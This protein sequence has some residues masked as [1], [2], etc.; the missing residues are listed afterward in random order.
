MESLRAKSASSSSDR[1]RKQV[2]LWLADTGT[3]TNAPSESSSSSSSEITPRHSKTRALAR[4]S[5]QT[6]QETPES[7]VAAPGAPHSPTSVMSTSTTHRVATLRSK[8]SRYSNKMDYCDDS[9]DEWLPPQA[10][11]SAQSRKRPQS[12][13]EKKEPITMHHDVLLHIMSYLSPKPLQA[14]ANS[15]RALQASITTDMVVKSAM[16]QGGQGQKL[17]DAIRRL[18]TKQSIHPPSPKRLLKLVNCATAGRCEECGH[19]YGLYECWM[20]VRAFG[21]FCCE[22]CCLQ[23]CQHIAKYNHKTFHTNPKYN[24]IARF[25]ANERISQSVSVS[26]ARANGRIV[27]TVTTVEAVIDGEVAGE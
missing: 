15:S 16:V 11:R 5:R 6:M 19:Y 17:I 23:E 3:I 8:K 27:V 20:N 21:L 9:D 10:A 7:V 12:I 1:K 22:R 24:R 25:W 14:F 18:M 4:L 26:T 13:K 2:A